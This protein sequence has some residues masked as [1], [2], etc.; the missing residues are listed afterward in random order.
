MFL[1]ANACPFKRRFRI[2]IVVVVG[3]GGVVV[4]GVVVGV[5][6]GNGALDGFRRAHEIDPRGT[7]G[8]SLR[9]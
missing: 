2:T 9:Q 7:F 8:G 5:A 4:V 6:A 1:A 3:G